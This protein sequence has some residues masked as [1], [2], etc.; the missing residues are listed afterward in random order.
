MTIQKLKF[1]RN[2]APDNQR[3]LN[4]MRNPELAHILVMIARHRLLKQGP[5]ITRARNITD[6][7]DYSSCVV[8]WVLFVLISS[9]HT[10]SL[11]VWC[12]SMILEMPSTIQWSFLIASPI[13]F[14]TSPSRNISATLLV[15]FILALAIAIPTSSR[16]IYLVFPNVAVGGLAKGP[17]TSEQL[18]AIER[19]AYLQYRDS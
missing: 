11:W 8:Y 1:V 7:R 18:Q 16:C 5:I 17:C 3:V 15:K 13:P 2:T 6:Y 14:V 12:I 19:A 10:L 9:C 4:F